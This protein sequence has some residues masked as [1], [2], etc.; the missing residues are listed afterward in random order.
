MQ[1]NAQSQLRHMIERSG[2]SNHQEPHCSFNKWPR[3][4]I[5]IAIWYCCN[6]FSQWRRSY[7]LKGLRQRHIAVVIWEP[8]IQKYPCHVVIMVSF[9]RYHWPHPSDDPWTRTCRP[10]SSWSYWST[11]TAG[12]YRPPRGN[13][14]P[15][16]S[17]QPWCRLPW[18]SRAFRSSWLYR[19]TWTVRSTWT[20]RTPRPSWSN[21]STR[22]WRR[23]FTIPWPNWTHRTTRT[24][25]ST[26]TERRS[27]Q[28]RTIRTPRTSW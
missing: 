11:G 12:Q 21:W 6:P 10:W 27:R 7:W 18:T 16:P 3:P 23:W 13:R 9:S 14:L 19:A 17:W 8:I 20:A 4:C 24:I 1:I 28:P 15:G 2:V 5:T 26:W 22:F 25:W